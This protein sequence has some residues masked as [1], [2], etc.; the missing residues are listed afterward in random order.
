MK[1]P[2]QFGVEINTLTSVGQ[3]LGDFEV[4]ITGGFWV[5]AGAKR[6]LRSRRKTAERLPDYRASLL[7][8]H[9]RG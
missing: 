3:L 8:F 1:T 9:L 4:A 7:G 5:A 6:S 2:G